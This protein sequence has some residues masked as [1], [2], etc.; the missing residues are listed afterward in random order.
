MHYPLLNHLIGSGRH[1]VRL[2]L[3]KPA[4]QHEERPLPVLG[5]VGFVNVTLRLCYSHLELY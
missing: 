1:T 3:I 5:Y 4:S 2:G